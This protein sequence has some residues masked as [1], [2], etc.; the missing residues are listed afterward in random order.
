MPLWSLIAR[1]C[2]QVLELYGIHVDSVERRFFRDHL[3]NVAQTLRM[4]DEHIDGETQLSAA[5]H[6]INLDVEA[7]DEAESLFPLEDSPE[8]NPAQIG[9]ELESG[10]RW[11]SVTLTYLPMDFEDDHWQKMQELNELTCTPENFDA[12]E[13]EAS[14]A[15]NE[16]EKL[17][18]NT[19]CNKSDSPIVGSDDAVKWPDGTDD[20]CSD[21]DV[22]QEGSEKEYEL[23]ALEI[24]QVVTQSGLESTKEQLWRLRLAQIRRKK[25]R[26]VKDLVAKEHWRSKIKSLSANNIL[27]RYPD[28]LDVVEEE[29]ETLKA[30]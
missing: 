15:A 6:G 1:I 25:R 27:V 14:A 13:R 24:S 26:L 21:E 5:M 22:L 29:L 23:D 2:F 18:A 12:F 4:I 8:C 10:L 9:A 17:D 16:I 30:S 3:D 11:D 19:L 28:V 7:I 20:E